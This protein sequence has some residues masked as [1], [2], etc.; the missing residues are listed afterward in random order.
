MKLPILPHL[1]IYSYM[2]MITDLWEN[3]FLLFQVVTGNKYMQ[4]HVVHHFSVTQKSHHA[5]PFYLPPHVPGTHTPVHTAIRAC[6]TTSV[7]Y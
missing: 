4:Y 2:N 3:K 6:I 5:S 7:L 1:F